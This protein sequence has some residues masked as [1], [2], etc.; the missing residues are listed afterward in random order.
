MMGQHIWSGIMRPSLARH[1]KTTYRHGHSRWPGSVSNAHGKIP[2]WSKW[3]VPHAE[4][5]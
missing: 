1:S 3:S 2:L 5:A 4:S